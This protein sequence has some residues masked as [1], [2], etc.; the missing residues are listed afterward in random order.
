MEKIEDEVDRVLSSRSEATVP[1]KRRWNKRRIGMTILLTVAIG[2]MVVTGALMTF[3]WR[4]E[5]SIETEPLILIDGVPSEE[6]VV[7]INL[8]GVV[9]GSNYE[10]EHTIML[11]PDFTGG[12]FTVSFNLIDGEDGLTVSV[13]NET[14][15]PLT[16]LVLYPGAVCTFRILID[17]NP[18]FMSSDNAFSI[19]ILPI[20]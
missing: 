2:A 15:E 18:L 19:E 13:V 10:Y 17:I 7:S 1:P 16:D 5:F 3:I 9:P 20:G 6:S 8:T 4:G 12:S 11:N 14:Y